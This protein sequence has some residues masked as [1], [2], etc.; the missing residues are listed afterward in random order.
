[1]LR[2]AAVVALLP[3]ATLAGKGKARC[4][5]CDARSVSPAPP[6]SDTHHHTCRSGINAR[7]CLR[8]IMQRVTGGSCTA[9]I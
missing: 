8:P 1:M 7:A 5:T 9:H 3:A 6:H 2:S 4:E